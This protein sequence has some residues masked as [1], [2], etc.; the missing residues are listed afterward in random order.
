LRGLFGEEADDGGVL[1][2]PG[3]AGG[4]ARAVAGFVE[5]GFGVDVARGGGVGGGA[6]ED[7]EEGGP[8]VPGGVVGGGRAVGEG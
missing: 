6:D 7:G 8:G 1:E 5:D 4:A 2:E 3:E